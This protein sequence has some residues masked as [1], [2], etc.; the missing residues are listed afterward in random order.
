MMKRS[1]WHLAVLAAAGMCSL[2][3]CDDSNSSNLPKETLTLSETEIEH[4]GEPDTTIIATNA[5]WLR[6]HDI[7]VEESYYPTTFTWSFMDNTL[8]CNTVINNS[9]ATLSHE[10]VN[11]QF[12]DGNLTIV[13]DILESNCSY[14]N[15]SISL[16]YE[17]GQIMKIAGKKFTALTGA[18]NRDFIIEPSYM[19]FPAK[20]GTIT[21]QSTHEFWHIDEIKL[22]D[23]RYFIPY[24][25]EQ[26]EQITR[27]W[28]ELR[29]DYKEV[30]ITLA[31]N[32]TGESRTFHVVIMRG[33][34]YRHILG[35]Q[36][37]E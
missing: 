30:S 4:D 35:T 29:T 27:E 37:A 5:K 13:T 21:A 8:D 2:C 23:V 26:P 20:G 31:P 25:P 24:S 32:E 9:T 33:D 18:P 16:S 12:C 14:L 15:F 22:D 34:D 6:V 7:T 28:L 36:A 1:L 10:W 11:V 3:A 17:D 19:E